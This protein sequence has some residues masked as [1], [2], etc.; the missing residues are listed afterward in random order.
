MAADLK[1]VRYTR[2]RSTLA[3]AEG[4]VE[5]LYVLMACLRFVLCFCQVALQR[6]DTSLPS[7]AFAE[8]KQNYT[9]Q[10]HYVFRFIK[11]A[12]MYITTPTPPKL[13]NNNPIRINKVRGIEE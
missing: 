6:S 2:M 4:Y 12:N 7:F 11:W 1:R 3:V 13:K 9:G 10:Y 8:Q 5:P